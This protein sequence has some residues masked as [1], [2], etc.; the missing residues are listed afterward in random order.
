MASAT[1]TH[2]IDGKAY[3]YPNNACPICKPDVTQQRDA[4]T[5]PTAYTKGNTVVLKF[6][7]ACMLTTTFW[8]KQKVFLMTMSSIA[9]TADGKLIRDNAN[10]PIWNKVTRRVPTDVLKTFVY[11]LSVAVKNAEGNPSK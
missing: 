4:G 3:T 11:E 6:S 10:K 7:K 8:G 9:R 5:Q 2:M 1:H